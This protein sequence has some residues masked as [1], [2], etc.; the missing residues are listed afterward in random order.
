VIF[1]KI[2]YHFLTISSAIF[3]YP[4]FTVTY[5]SG[6]DSVPR[7]DAHLAVYSAKKTVSVQYDTP[8]IKGLPVTMHVQENVDGVY[9][10]SVIRKTYEDPYTLELKELYAMVMDGKAVKTTA[11]DA[12]KD[13][14]I[15][16]MLFKAAAS[17]K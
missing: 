6:L 1:G 3:K 7:F 12:K 2:A 14:E 8:Y 4:T 15:F 11:E 5:E 13:L 16:R 10:E 9:K 17:N